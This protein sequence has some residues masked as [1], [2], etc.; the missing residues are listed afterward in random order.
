M[1]SWT[2]VK[3]L[4]HEADSRATSDGTDIYYIVG[5]TDI[6]KYDVSAATSTQI[7]DTNTWD[8]TSDVIDSGNGNNLCW[9]GTSLF[10]GIKHAGG[11]YNEGQVWEYDGSSWTKVYSPAASSNHG[12]DLLKSDSTY[13]VVSIS[14]ATG[15]DI[16]AHSTDGSS[17]NASTTFGTDPKIFDAVVDGAGND[18]AQGIFATATD[19]SDDRITE[20]QAGNWAS[21]DDIADSAAWFHA[22]GPDR[23]W[24][25]ESGTYKWTTDD[26]STD[27]TPATNR[28]P[29]RSLGLPYSVAYGASGST[30]NLYYW[31]AGSNDWDAGESI[32]AGAT[33]NSLG[34]MFRMTDKEAYAIVRVSGNDQIWQRDVPIV[35]ADFTHS[36]DGIPG[37]II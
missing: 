13:I 21:V 17:W 7:A 34:H 31:D 15:A 20:F 35:N 22:H 19:S 37:S 25:V 36:A 27:N 26:F 3:D 30:L 2:K 24:K 14:T 11:T 10:I 4:A 12:I 16:R 28:I 8:S 33:V 23:Q 9:F 1:A 5:T 29:G 6:Y 18:T 32:S